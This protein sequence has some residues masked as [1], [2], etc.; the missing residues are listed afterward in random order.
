MLSTQ[1]QKH[2]LEDFK[3]SI[4]LKLSA[5]WV[6]VMFCY[7][8][9]DFFSLFVPGRIKGLMDGNSGVGVTT[10]SSLLSFAIMMTIP[11]LM[12]FFSLVLKP[13]INR[14][15]NI[16]AG[17]LF[18]LIMALILT[19]SMSEWKIFYAYLACIEIILTSSVV[20]L[21]LRWPRVKSED[22]VAN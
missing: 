12:I 1:T 18:T 19:K 20:W 4:K 16:I 13:Q 8:Y 10:P 3:I 11:S 9:G 6:A 7:V 14:W 17:V 2:K 5:L 21:A 15:T 22:K